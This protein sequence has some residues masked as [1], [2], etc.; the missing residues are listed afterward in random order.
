MGTSDHHPS[1][2][3]TVSANILTAVAQSVFDIGHLERRRKIYG[4]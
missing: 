2:D 3:M 1:F 4:R